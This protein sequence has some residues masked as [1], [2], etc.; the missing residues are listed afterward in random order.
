MNIQKLGVVANI[1]KKEI[2]A[3][4]GDVIDSIPAGVRV[5]GLSDTAG[6]MEGSRIEKVNSLSECDAIVALGG[7]GTFLRAARIVEREEIPVLG[8]KIRSLGFLA[9]DDPVNAITD[10]FDGKCTIQ[11][12]MRVEVL[13]RS[14]S[15]PEDGFTALNDVVLHGVGVS[16]VLH[17]RTYV[18]GILLGEYLADGAIISTPTG[19]TAYSLAAGGP[20]INPVKMNAIV[21]TPLCPHSL[22][23]RPIVISSEETLTLELVEQ[24][25]ETLITIDGQSTHSIKGGEAIIIR[26]SNRVTRL[27]VTGE[28]NFYDLVRRKLHWG[29]VLRKH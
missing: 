27:L 8:L 3:V 26:Q 5:L 4:M 29:G 19:S 7:D 9:E 13:R 23:V 28:Y 25:Q 22:S 20:I 15:E 12:R 2:K 21:I 16:R 18:D 17:L 14:S 10:L 6:L 24:S 11:E 1:H